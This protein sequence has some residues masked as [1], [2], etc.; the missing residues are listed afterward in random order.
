MYVGFH[1]NYF[2]VENRC[3][4]IIF[5]T[6]NVLFMFRYYSADTATRPASA[7]RRGPDRILPANK[8][9][10]DQNKIMMAKG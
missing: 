3:R 6:L 1:N 8:V 10:D 9:Q 7:N 4:I 2:E 5:L